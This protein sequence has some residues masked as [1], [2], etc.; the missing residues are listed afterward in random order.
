LLRLALAVMVL[1]CFLNFSCLCLLAAALTS[2]SIPACQFSFHFLPDSLFSNF[3]FFFSFS[4]NFSLCIKKVASF[5]SWPII[6]FSYLP[7]DFILSFFCLSDIIFSLDLNGSSASNF[8]GIINGVK[9]FAFL[10]IGK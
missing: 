4:I 3:C 2:F 6:G 7:S 9:A 1:C 10:S 5:S 8:F